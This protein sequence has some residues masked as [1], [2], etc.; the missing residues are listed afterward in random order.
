MPDYYADDKLT[1][2]T[3]GDFDQQGID[4]QYMPSLVKNDLLNIMKDVSL[5]G[6]A[7]GNGAMYLT[8]TQQNPQ[9]TFN[10]PPSVDLTTPADVAADCLG[11]VENNV[12]PLPVDFTVD[13]GPGIETQRLGIKFNNGAVAG[14]WA[15]LHDVVLYYREDYPAQQGET[16]AIN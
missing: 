10:D 4:W 5:V 11:P 6:R 2:D 14:N 7:L 3:H 9:I 8:P 1:V 16:K 15:E 12:A 13:L